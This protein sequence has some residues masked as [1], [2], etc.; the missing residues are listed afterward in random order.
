MLPPGQRIV[1]LSILVIFILLLLGMGGDMVVEREWFPAG[2]ALLSALVMV[3][4]LV[5]EIRPEKT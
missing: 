5:V 1:T 2:L 4:G 3:L